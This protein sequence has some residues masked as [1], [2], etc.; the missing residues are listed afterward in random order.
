MDK[1]TSAPIR[2]G[3]IRLVRS[4]DEVRTALKGGIHNRLARRKTAYPFLVISEV[5][6]PVARDPG[7]AN[8][9]GHLTID[10]LYDVYVAAL[11]QVEADD[12]D[13][14]LAWLLSGPGA[15]AALQQY[16]VGQHLQRIDRVAHPPMGPE[17]DATGRWVVRQGGTYRIVTDIALTIPTP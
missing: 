1:I 17:R 15:E 16:I 8:N 12:L 3:L 5:S 10:A 13:Q 11:K 4:N 7:G 9:A 2:Y 6:A 14:L